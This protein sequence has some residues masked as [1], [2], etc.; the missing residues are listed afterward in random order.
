MHRNSEL[1]SVEIHATN[2]HDKA[3]K[4]TVSSQQPEMREKVRRKVERLTSP[5]VE[6]GENGQTGTMEQCENLDKELISLSS[7]SGWEE[8]TE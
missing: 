7:S 2:E 5:K 3:F 4:I 6:K 1:C 8:V